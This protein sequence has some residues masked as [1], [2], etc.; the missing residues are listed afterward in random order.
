MRLNEELSYEKNVD[1]DLNGANNLEILLTL[2][3]TSKDFH[4]LMSKKEQIGC[5]T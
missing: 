2:R 3:L 5:A 4:W 1:K